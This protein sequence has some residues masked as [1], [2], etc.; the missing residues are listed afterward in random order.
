MWVTEIYIQLVS[1]CVIWKG[2][3]FDFRKRK[4]IFMNLN[5]KDY[6]RLMFI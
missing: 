2:I 1:K 5:C 4:L 3:W 6:V